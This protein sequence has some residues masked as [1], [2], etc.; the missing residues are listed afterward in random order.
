MEEQDGELGAALALARR[1]LNLLD[2]VGEKGAAIHLQRAIDAMTRTPG[3]RT[4][5]EAA[6]LLATPD[7]QELQERLGLIDGEVDSSTADGAA[8]WFGLRLREERCARRLTQ[9]DLSKK[10]DLSA[11]YISLMERGRANPTIDTMIAL[12]EALSL[13]AWNLVAQKS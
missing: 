8:R 3:P 7:A 10:A 1:A 11:D 13:E 2:A 4:E 6:A 9:N 5:E 12:A